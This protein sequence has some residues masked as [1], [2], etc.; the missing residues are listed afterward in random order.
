MTIVILEIGIINSIPNEKS[1]WCPRLV[2]IRPFG[3][4]TTWIFRLHEFVHREF[5]HPIGINYFI[6]GFF[7]KIWF[8]LL[9]ALCTNCFIQFFQ[10]L[11][12]IFRT[13]CKYQ[14]LEIRASHQLL[15]YRYQELFILLLLRDWKSRIHYKSR[16]YPQNVLSHLTS[17]W[18]RHICVVKSIIGD[19]YNKFWCQKSSPQWSS[20][21]NYNERQCYFAGNHLYKWLR[22][23]QSNLIVLS[24][25]RMNETKSLLNAIEMIPT[26]YV[27]RL[28]TNAH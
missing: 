15:G 3:V 8:G 5:F 26:W 7:V 19:E 23:A 12:L 14:S 27:E 2:W 22:S 6:V 18:N 21:W 20:H 11:Y 13:N 25:I 24:C 17:R 28:L 1:M 16:K 4:D 10:L 9:K